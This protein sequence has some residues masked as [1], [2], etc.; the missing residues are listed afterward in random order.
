MFMKKIMITNPDEA[1]K[2]VDI[3]NKYQDVPIQLKN[4]DYVIDGHSI[5]G[6]LSLDMSQPT[7]LVTDL[8]PTQEFLKDMEL[9][10]V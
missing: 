8:D 10:A 3:A 7:E 9:F 2:F 5:M 4:G 6:I 1:K